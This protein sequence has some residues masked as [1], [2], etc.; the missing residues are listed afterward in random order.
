MSMT[1]AE[2]LADKAK[3]VPASTLFTVGPEV[4]VADAVALMTEKSDQL[5]HRRRA[6]PDAGADYAS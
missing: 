5:C 3:Q 4:G 1:V 6:G 2:L